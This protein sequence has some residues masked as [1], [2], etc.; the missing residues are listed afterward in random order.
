M[1]HGFYILLD[2]VLIEYGL[3]CGTNRFGFLEFLGRGR[4]FYLLLDSSDMR[5][6]CGLIHLRDV[7]P[8][9]AQLNLVQ[10]ASDHVSEILE[11]HRAAVHHR[12]DE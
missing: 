6:D 7:S 12:L 2:D 5:R 9:V 1:V 10:V 8:Q 11:R 4:S 3:L